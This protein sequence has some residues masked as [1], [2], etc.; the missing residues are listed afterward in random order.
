MQ[1]GLHS[2]EQ[3]SIRRS[4]AH[5]LDNSV[6]WHKKSE[7]QIKQEE[8]LSKKLLCNN[9]E[10]LDRASSAVELER[11][12]FQNHSQSHLGAR[13]KSHVDIPYI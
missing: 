13:I 3:F 11:Q 8:L 7:M 6:N 10:S 1:S 2:Q 9:A 12:S 4:S 5:L